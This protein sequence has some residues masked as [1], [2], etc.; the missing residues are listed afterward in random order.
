MAE[1]RCFTCEGSFEADISSLSDPTAED[2]QILADAQ[3]AHVAGHPESL[4]TGA[5]PDSLL[6][7]RYAAPDP[8]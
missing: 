6:L 5:M 2:F 8:L 3:A 1:L 4:K 7:R